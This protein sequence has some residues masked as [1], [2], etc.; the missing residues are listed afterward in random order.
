VIHITVQREI[1]VQQELQLHGSVQDTLTKTRREESVSRRIV[2]TVL[3]DT[4]AMI[5]VSRPTKIGFVQQVIIVRKLQLPRQLNAQLVP[6]T[7]TREQEMKMTAIPVQKDSIVQRV[8]LLHNHAGTELTAQRE[9]PIQ[10][11][12]HKVT[13]AQQ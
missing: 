8:L 10:L 12:A 13:I 6:T 1:T 11:I 4:I 3:R 2:K 5:R 7:K 9:L